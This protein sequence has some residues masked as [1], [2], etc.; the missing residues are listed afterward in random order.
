MQNKL[1]ILITLSL[2]T[3]SL[4]YDR[5]KAVEYA[6]QYYKNINH[7]CGS[8]R[9]ACSP[10]GYY[11]NENCKYAKH[12]GDCANFVSQC[13]IAGG[14]SLKS[15]CK[16]SRC[17]VILGAKS[18]GVC[19]HKLGWKRACGKKLAPPEY[20]E[21]GDVIVYHEDSCE[22]RKTHVMIVTVGGKNAK[23]SGHSPNCKDRHWD[24]GKK[25]VYYE[26]LHYEGK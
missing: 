11:G 19:L 6:Y 24:Y 17:D 3:F 5:A 9:T 13:V 4:T 12:N 8:G 10:Y 14:V 23:V 1:Q 25:K 22:G 20:I 2:I 7:R 21:K 18:L 16:V 26:W 15:K